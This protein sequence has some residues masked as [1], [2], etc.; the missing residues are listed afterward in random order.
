MIDIIGDRAN[1]SD[2]SF[3]NISRL[4]SLSFSVTISMTNFI[5]PSD[6]LDWRSLTGI[7]TNKTISRTSY[8]M[9]IG[10]R[11]CIIQNFHFSC[12]TTRRL[13]CC[14]YPDLSDRVGVVGGLS[15]LSF[16]DSVIFCK[17]SGVKMCFCVFHINSGFHRWQQCSQ[18]CCKLNDVL[19][20]L[21]SK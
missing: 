18:V 11:L 20:R 6:K 3:R 2:I 17:R 12:G 14:L 8:K 15:K 10:T 13:I 5:N 1:S 21:D 16:G 19:T 4:V 7:N 9:M